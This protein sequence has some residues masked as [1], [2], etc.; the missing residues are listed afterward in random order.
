MSKRSK[1][2]AV[3]FDLG[4]VV[5]HGGYL[6]FINHYCL[7]CLTLSGK[8]KILELE[9]QVNLGNITEKQFYRALRTVFGIHL[10]VQEM[11]KII[12]NRAKKNKALLKIIRKLGRRRV[13][14][15]TNS[16]GHMALEV[17]HTQKIP[18]RKLFHRVFVSTRMHFVKPDRKAYRFVVSKLKVKPE[19]ALMIDDRLVNIRGARASGLNTILFK[20]TRQFQ[21]ALRKYE[22]V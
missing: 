16:I 4:G 3:I 5:V 10:S 1:I 20:N 6:D 17:L 9:R 8:R 13:A 15:F 19:E 21:K 18:A 14:I 12:M 7:K 2:K 11:H 22:F